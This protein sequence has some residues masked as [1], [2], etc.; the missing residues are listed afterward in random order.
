MAGDW[1][2]FENATPDKPEIYA[3]A[4]ELGIDPDA[5][6]GKLLRF[7]TWADQQAVSGNALNVTKNVID[8]I[9]YAPGFADALL[10]VD[11]L[12]VRSG[13]L[14]IP[15]FDRHNGQSAKK[16]AASNRRVAEHRQR[17]NAGSVTNVTP[18]ALPKA[19]PE[20]RR[21]DSKERERAGAKSPP[22]TPDLA[23]QAQAVVAAYPRKEKVADAL[24]IVLGQLRAGDSFEA[25]LSGTK[26]AAAIIR[27]LPSG[28]SNRYVPGAEAFFR[29][30][31][32][33]DDPETL[34]RQGDTKSGS[35]P[36]S[37][38]EADALLGGRAVNTD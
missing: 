15:H 25:M 11:W 1:I 14:A 35:K 16:R 30:K 8:R 22:G 18:E 21:E 38:E 28:A 7:W 37:D 19:L 36:M 5:V 23:E 31:R 12:Q 9:T 34:R 32:W 4:E 17:G 24:A 6:V 2:K 29:A 10:K 33:A 26:A 3:I 27:T 20:K 13:S